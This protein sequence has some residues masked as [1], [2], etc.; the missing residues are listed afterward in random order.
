MPRDK[1]IEKSKDAFIKALF[2]LLKHESLKKITI[3]Q[4]SL[5]SGYSKRT[6]YRY[7]KS[8]SDI[9]DQMFL[10]FLRNYKKYLLKVS[11]NSEN[12]PT[13]FIN[14]IWPNRE[15]IEILAHNDLLIPMLTKHIPIIIKTLLSIKVPWRQEKV[16]KDNYK[17]VLTY[18]I[19]GF[20]V[21]LDSIFKNS[22][23]KYPNEIIEN[24]QSSLREI[25]NN[26]NN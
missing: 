21:L 17:Y 24:L 5:E 1:I 7:F 13:I 25:S 4:L 26:I 10:K 6:Y 11:I 18:S 20:C 8:K 3:K 19:G 15:K 23:P 12:I 14:F 16:N 2:N 9:L 22:L